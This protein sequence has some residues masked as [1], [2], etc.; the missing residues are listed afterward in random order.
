MTADAHELP[1]NPQASSHSQ[2]RSQRH[3][4]NPYQIAYAARRAAPIAPHSTLWPRSVWCACGKRQR[5]TAVP[6]PGRWR[7]S[8]PHPVIR[9]KP[10]IMR[11]RNRHDRS[12]SRLIRQGAQTT[13]K[14]GSICNV[15]IKCYHARA[16]S[17]RVHQTARNM[18]FLAGVVKLR[19]IGHQPDENVDF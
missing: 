10:L 9:E 11:Q 7:I 17:T 5:D 1:W 2:R 12:V 15:S 19:C 13:K 16:P 6:D 3:R 4:Y 8:S 18:A 14:Y